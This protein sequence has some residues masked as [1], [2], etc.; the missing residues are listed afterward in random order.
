MWTC[1]KCG[2]GNTGVFFRNCGAK[3]RLDF[4]SN[5]N[6]IKLS[7]WVSRIIVKSRAFVRTRRELCVFSLCYALAFFSLNSI[8]QFWWWLA[9]NIK[10]QELILDGFIRQWMGK[11]ILL[12]LAVPLFTEIAVYSLD[13]MKI[14]FLRG[15]GLRLLSLLVGL[16]LFYLV[17]GGIILRALDRF[18]FYHYNDTN[19]EDMLAVTGFLVI[20]QPLTAFFSFG[21]KTIAI[22]IF[23]RKN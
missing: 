11:Y 7:L 18:N 23:A 5:N 9:S 1:N 2:T 21:L 22:S 4:R 13:K 15:L 19:T 6:R 12:Y 16:L 10:T 17:Y 3:Q 20:F 8:N 14:G